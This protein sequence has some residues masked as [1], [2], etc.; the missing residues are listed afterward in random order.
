V[1]SRE[2]NA[3]QEEIFFILLKCMKIKIFDAIKKMLDHLNLK[4]Y[5]L[6]AAIV[7]TKYGYLLKHNNEE[8]WIRNRG[9]L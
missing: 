6:N 9:A 8:Y 1:H 3:W 5:D 7:E 2:K 4:K